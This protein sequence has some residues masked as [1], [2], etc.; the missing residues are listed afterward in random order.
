MEVDDAENTSEQRLLSAKQPNALR[1][2]DAVLVGD[3]FKYGNGKALDNG[4]SGWKSK[5]QK[6]T[7]PVY[8]QQTGTYAVE[9]EYALKEGAPLNSY[10]VKIGE[11]K[12]TATTKGAGTKRDVTFVKHEIG[13]IEIPE[14][15]TVIE[16]FSE[17]TPDNDLMTLRALHLTPINEK[18]DTVN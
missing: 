14:G 6:V 10:C 13:S 5:N 8:L 11:E 9:A 16:I 7:W 15:L 2:F 3:G 12:L 18:Q 1:A 17:D 4:V